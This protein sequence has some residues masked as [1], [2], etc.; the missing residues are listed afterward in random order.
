M[1]WGLDFTLLK[2]GIGDLPPVVA[3]SFRMP[4]AALAIGLVAW[5]SAGR[6]IPRAMTHRDRAVA[7]LSGA[8][9]LGAGS[10]FFLTAIQTLGAGRAGAIGAVSP[11]F[12]MMLAAVFLRERPG[13]LTVVGT[14]VAVAGVTV[15]SL[16]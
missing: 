7:V 12:A 15:L 1:M 13:W 8:V 3:N 14:F 11:V 5:K 4:A 2:I 16:T 10:M 6:I 9:G